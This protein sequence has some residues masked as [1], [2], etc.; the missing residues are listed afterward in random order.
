LPATDQQIEVAI[1]QA[2]YKV[3]AN[4]F[5]TQTASFG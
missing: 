2:A 3:L 5:P 1:S 4:Q